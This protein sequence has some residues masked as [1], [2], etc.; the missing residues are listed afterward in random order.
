ME[1]KQI[2]ETWRENMKRI[3]D[4]HEVKGEI[5]TLLMIRGNKSNGGPSAVKYSPQEGYANFLL[6]LHICIRVCVC[7]LVW[8]LTHLLILVIFFPSPENKGSSGSWSVMGCHVRMFLC[9]WRALEEHVK[10]TDRR[11]KSFKW[12]FKTHWGLCDERNV[13]SASINRMAPVK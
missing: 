1:R 12:C 3:R 9:R 5:W 7:L 6:C 10:S 11:K 13:A 2:G 4:R 8:I